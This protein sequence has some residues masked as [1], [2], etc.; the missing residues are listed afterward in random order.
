MSY[1]SG[2]K[3][4]KNENDVNLRRTQIPHN[5]KKIIFEN[6][7]IDDNI[8]EIKDE[9]E[10]SNKVLRHNTTVFTFEKNNF[11]FDENKKEIN[12]NEHDLDKFFRQNNNSMEP[13]AS[14][15]FFCILFRSVL[16]S[17]PYVFHE[18][19]CSRGQRTASESDHVE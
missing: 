18:G 9:N 5:N 3:K 7:N 19:L 2:N 12:N 1:I 4:I 8:K 6:L 16:Q 13:E 15:L 17:G 11:L 14:M 10:I